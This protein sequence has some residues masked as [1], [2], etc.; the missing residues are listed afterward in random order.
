MNAPSLDRFSW[1]LAGE[2]APPV[3]LIVPRQ[4]ELPVKPDEQVFPAYLMEGQ[5]NEA[6]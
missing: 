2:P 1:R 5:E 6:V 3:R 4:K